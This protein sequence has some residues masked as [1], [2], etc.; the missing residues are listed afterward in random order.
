[1]MARYIDANVLY[2]KFCKLDSQALHHVG[3]LDPKENREEWLI[4][5]A[6]LKERSAY[7]HDVY[8]AP[9]VDVP[10]TNVGDMIIRQSA[11]DALERE[12]TYCTA[13]K[14][15]YT[16]T[17]YFKEY[18][19]GLTDGIKALNKLPSAQPE[20]KTGRW[21]LVKGSNGKD[22]HKCS[23]CLHTQEITGIKNYCAV[24]GADMRGKER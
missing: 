5:N 13:Y 3:S 16:Q 6:I 23:E 22:Y 18:N 15:G 8:N 7:K 12:K 11:I 24:C 1:M 9:T 2:E 4:W 20:R 10:D 21:I 14:D 19:M 17:D